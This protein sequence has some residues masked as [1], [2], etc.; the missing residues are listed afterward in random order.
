MARK[1]GSP[2]AR[3]AM[4]VD[5][6]ERAL[7]KFKR[8][9]ENAERNLPPEVVDRIIAS[10]KNGVLPEELADLCTLSF[11]LEKCA[12]RTEDVEEI[13]KAASGSWHMRR[14]AAAAGRGN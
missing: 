12:R 1:L 4:A 2:N 13:Y 7:R 6:A 5:C 3:W 8:G 11:A 9:A 14:M 10:V